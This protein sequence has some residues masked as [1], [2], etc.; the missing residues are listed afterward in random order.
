[1]GFGGA[2]AHLFAREGARVVLTD[3]LEEQGE[4]SAAQLREKGCDAVFM[5]LDVAEEDAWRTAVEATV[6][7]YGK[8]DVLVNNAGSGGS[9]SIEKTTVEAWDAMIDSHLKGTF[10]GM[11]HC[12]PEMRK[13]GGGSIVNVSSIYGLVGTPGG[14]AYSAAKGGIR[15]LTKAATLQFAPDGIR[16]NSVHPG[17][18]MTPMTARA[19][20]NPAHTSG[21]VAQTPMGRLADPY[22][23]AYGILFLASDESSF[24]TGAEL[25]IDGGM[26]AQ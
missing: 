14:S 17:F 20:R 21:R 6:K 19:H 25:T 9:A 23:I 26:T 11:K 22:D 4:R 5:R 10:L 1:M 7:T 12:A 24:V 3:I 2:T 15:A 13:T 8:L 16:V 18:A